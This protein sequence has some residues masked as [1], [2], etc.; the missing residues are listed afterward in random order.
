MK[1]YNDDVYSFDKA[2]QAVIRNKLK[3]LLV[4]FS[5]FTA[6]IV[7]ASVIAISIVG[8]VVS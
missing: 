7:V 5:I 8:F 1:Y 4:D 6:F 3:E 2:E